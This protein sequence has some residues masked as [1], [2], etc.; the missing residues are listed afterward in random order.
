VGT[1]TTAPKMPEM[2][3]WY[4]F[5][6]MPDRQLPSRAHSERFYNRREAASKCKDEVT[7]ATFCRNPLKC[8]SSKCDHIDDCTEVQ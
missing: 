3:F 1:E 2:R 7:A 4:V 5:A 6:K 8:A